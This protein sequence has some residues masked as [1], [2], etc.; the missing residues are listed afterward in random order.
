M[1][2]ETCIYEQSPE[3]S[4]THACENRLS[5]SIYVGEMPIDLYVERYF[6]NS[7]IQISHFDSISLF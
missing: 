2:K 7:I 5:I 1:S 4:L 3:K 6:T